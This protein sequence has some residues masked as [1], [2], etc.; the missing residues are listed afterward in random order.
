MLAGRVD[1]ELGGSEDCLDI[2]GLNYYPDNHSVLPME[3]CRWRNA[4]R[5][6][7]QIP[8]AQC[9]QRYQRPDADCRKPALRVK[10][11]PPGLR[12]IE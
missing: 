1:K 11:A 8:L 9:W 2:L 5:A 4:A 10:R 3:R 12:E 6:P 7:L